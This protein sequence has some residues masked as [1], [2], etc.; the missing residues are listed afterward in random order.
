MNIVISS[1]LLLVSF[2]SESMMSSVKFS[3]FSLNNIRYGIMH[4]S[5]RMFSNFV[6][7]TI[8]NERLWRKKKQNLP[9][10]S[11]EQKHNACDG[12]AHAN[13]FILQSNKISML[14]ICKR[15]WTSHWLGR[16]GIGLMCA[17]Q[18]EM[19]LA[20]VNS[21]SDNLE[22]NHHFIA[23]NIKAPENDALISKIRSM[24][25]NLFKCSHI[26]SNN[27]TSRDLRI[28]RFVKNHLSLHK[29]SANC[30]QLTT[31]NSNS[32]IKGA[33][34]SRW[35][36]M[37]STGCAMIG[38]S[39]LMYDKNTSAWTQSPHISTIVGI[40]GVGCLCRNIIKSLSAVFN[41]FSIKSDN[42]LKLIIA[43]LLSDTIAITC[44]NLMFMKLFDMKDKYEQAISEINNLIPLSTGARLSSL[45]KMLH[46][47]VKTKKSVDNSFLTSMLVGSSVH[48]ILKSEKTSFPMFVATVGE[49][50]YPLNEL[51]KLES[52]LYTAECAING[53]II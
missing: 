27:N 50:L 37:F 39:H 11:V 8:V 28:L 18:S 23:N 42:D 40:A 41:T 31:I 9:D 53:D 33:L 30:K 45:N 6:D 1:V 5:I 35:A 12:K 21:I 16:L 20:S 32:D 43:Y 46:T 44:S 26:S 34:L 13:R 15:A 4:D 25:L 7:K 47:L 24:F 52:Q 48:G 49:V 22:T 14:E 10:V 36:C 2:S 3:P 19:F 17:G 38:Y 29:P 51:N